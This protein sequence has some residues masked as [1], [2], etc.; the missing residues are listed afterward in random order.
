MKNL[1]YDCDSRW[2]YKLLFVGNI[3]GYQEP[4]EGCGYWLWAVQC[5]LQLTLIVPFLVQS[6]QIKPWFG[7]LV[8]LLVIIG[9]QIQTGYILSVNNCR[10]GFLAVENF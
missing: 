2:F 7:N 5:D 9:A 1:W 8:Q 4:T 3:Q 6:Y 10:A